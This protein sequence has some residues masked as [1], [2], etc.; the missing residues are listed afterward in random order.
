MQLMYKVGVKVDGGESP[1]K[2]DCCLH[3]R[4]DIERRS[5]QDRK[6]RELIPHGKRD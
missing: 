2:G 3:G 5:M 6:E 1:P 4:R